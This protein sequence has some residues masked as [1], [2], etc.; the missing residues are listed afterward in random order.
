VS[1]VD[2]IRVRIVN[3]AIVSF[4]PN[5]H[6]RSQ[7]IDTLKHKH[8]RIS[9]SQM[10][11]E[12]D[13]KS[14]HPDIKSVKTKLKTFYYLT[15]EGDEFCDE[16]ATVVDCT[17]SEKADARA[18]FAEPVPPPAPP[19]PPAPPDPPAPS[20]P[21]APAPSKK[22]AVVME[23]FFGPPVKKTAVGYPVSSAQESASLVAYMSNRIMEAQNSV[24]FEET[25]TKSFP[26]GSTETL[27][28]RVKVTPPPEK[29]PPPQPSSFDITNGKRGHAACSSNCNHDHKND[30][31]M[32]MECEVQEETNVNQVSEPSTS[33]TTDQKRSNKF[34][35]ASPKLPMAPKSTKD[36]K[37]NTIYRRL[38][39]FGRW[40]ACSNKW[41]RVC[42]H[43]F[44][45]GSQCLAYEQ[46]STGFCKSHGGGKRCQATNED[47]SPC[48]KSAI[49]STN[50]CVGHGGGKRCQATNKDGS[51]CPT[52]A[53]GST[54]FC[55]YHGGGK[56]CQ[57]T[58]EDGS[59]CPKSAQGSTDFCKSHGG[60]K[61]CQAKNEDGS[62]CPKS[63]LDTTGFC[64]GHG[65]GKRCQ[66]TKEDGS[67]CPTAAKGAT[68]FCVRHGGGKRCKATN[69]DGSPC[70]KSAE[71]S[72]DFCKYHGGGKRCQ[73]TK[74]DGS[75]CPTS[76][77]GSTDFC[78]RHGGGKRCKGKEDGGCPNSQGLAKYPNKQGKQHV[79]CYD[80]SIADGAHPPHKPG[81]SL[82]ACQ[83]FD[84]LESAY[85]REIGNGVSTETRY[86]LPHTHCDRVAMKWGEDN[87]RRN[88]IPNSK[89]RPDSFWEPT[90]EEKKMGI[91]GVVFLYH[92][93]HFHGYPPGH[94]KHDGCFNWISKRNGG[95]R[96]KV[97]YKDL[98]EKT[99]QTTRLYLNHGFIVRVIWGHEYLALSAF[100]NILSIVHERR[101]G[102]SSFAS[103]SADMVVELDEDDNA[104][105]F[106]E[107]EVEE[108]D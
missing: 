95:K 47:G 62:P 101:P 71:G 57:A 84:Q 43:T 100:T 49:G 93:N 30:P 11:E 33:N 91:N 44:E 94:L 61:R 25:K 96:I 72:T 16:N 97:C 89:V 53:H 15:R 40:K 36:A 66:A 90:I 6:L 14:W 29:I 74:E 104:S 12:F 81:A 31:S 86:E 106:D 27:T 24:E 107:D 21:S 67:P 39:K 54:D 34:T 63:A 10:V 22:R 17:D 51:P 23:D 60:G 1:T 102:A 50:F 45:D 69:E 85:K 2:E 98:Y 26:D 56:R 20:A 68:E 19:A 59:P 105:D 88:L 78:I 41:L 13:R 4:L 103:T 28:T 108:E 65:G 46:G 37:K 3:I 9:A 5:R 87:E 52:A 42:N 79:L 32:A 82:E 7:I 18:N 48:P 70:P 77:E 8:T 55:K 35:P 58:N 75:P 76:A 99:E 83:C 64:V 80:C 38:G 92:G 73:A